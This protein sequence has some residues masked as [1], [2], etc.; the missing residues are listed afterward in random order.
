M[1]TLILLALVSVLGMLT[2]NEYVD[3]QNDLF[4]NKLEYASYI[5]NAAHN[6]IDGASENECGR[7]QDETGTE[8]LCNY[9][10][11]NCWLEVK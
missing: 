8:Y 9:N 4:K 7:M 5:C 6:A 1:K 3:A 10:G 11:Q 2:V